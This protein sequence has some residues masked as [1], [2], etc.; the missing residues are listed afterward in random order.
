M[1]I[2]LDVLAIIVGYLAWQVV[3]KECEPFRNSRMIVITE[4][5]TP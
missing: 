4:L 5:A 2:A 1:D 3:H